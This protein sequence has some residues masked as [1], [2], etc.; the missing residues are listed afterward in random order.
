VRRHH[1]RGH[2][3]QLHAHAAVEAV[4]AGHLHAGRLATRAQLGL[5]LLLDHAK[6]VRLLVEP[7]LQ[8]CDVLRAGLQTVVLVKQLASELQLLRLQPGQL[9]CLLVQLLQGEHVKEAGGRGR[10]GLAPATRWQHATAPALW[11]GGRVSIQRGRQQCRG[12][13]G[14][15]GE[16]ASPV[17]VR[18]AH[19]GAAQGGARRG[20]R[21]GRA[22]LPLLVAALGRLG[23]GRLRVG[24]LPARRL[25]LPLQVVAALLLGQ[26]LLLVLARL[27]AQHA[28][29]RQRVLELRAQRCRVALAGLQRAGGS[30]REGAGMARRAG[31]L[32]A[33]AAARRRPLG[34]AHRPGPAVYRGGEGARGA[35]RRAPAAGPPAAPRTRPS[36]PPAPAPGTPA[37]RRPAAGPRAAAAGPRRRGAR[38][39][40]PAP[41]WPGQWWGARGGRRR[42]VRGRGGLRVQ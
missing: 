42:R 26:Q 10:V 41:P 1:R 15:R 7:L 16:G 34:T 5:Q 37:L 33:H 24:Q 22:H 27:A 11:R 25:G 32:G 13:G 9:S 39:P 20:R 12:G 21:P 19:F 30:S 23:L 17:S 3:G 38:R 8:A 40:A 36:P 18:A 29:L 2:H 35:P 14:E 31:A 28:E 4:S 6:G